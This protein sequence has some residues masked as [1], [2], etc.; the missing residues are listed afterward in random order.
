M[1]RVSCFFLWLLFVLGF[2]VSLYI[3]RCGQSARGWGGG[4]AC[5]LIT[6]AM[7][8]LIALHFLSGVVVVVVV[9]VVLA[10]AVVVRCSCG[11]CRC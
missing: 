1:F 10:L 5:S 8:L 4:T 6:E 11:G 7:R 9:V 2:W 3:I